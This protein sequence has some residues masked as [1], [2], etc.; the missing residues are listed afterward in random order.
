MKTVLIIIVC[1]VLVFVVIYAYQGGFKSIQ[2]ESITAGGETFVYKNLTGEY[3][4]SAVTMDEIYYKLL[5]EYKI[6][7]YK[8]CGI[9]Y[10][11]PK[12]VEKSKL[13][14]D[15]GCIVESKDLSKISELE[16][17][18]D[19]KELPKQEYVTASFPYKNKMSIIFGIMKVYPALKKYA[20][21]NN[22]DEDGPVIEIYDVPNKRIVYRKS[23]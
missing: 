13:R 3:K 22:L 14:C 2:V 12:K 15:A 20:I 17:V 5:N 21:K 6:E 11:N 10:D 7:T 23:L 1:I 18:Y 19:V 4:N 8:G 9:Y 16:G